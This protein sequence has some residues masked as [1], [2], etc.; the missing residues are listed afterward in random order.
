MS[1][2]N[3]E[4]RLPSH[5]T[6]L[7]VLAILYDEGSDRAI[8]RSWLERRTRKG[9]RTIENAITILKEFRAIDEKEKETPLDVHPRISIN[10]SAGSVGTVVTVQGIGWP[11]GQRVDIQMLPSTGSPG[12]DYV[13][14]AT[15]IV[16]SQGY[17]WAQFQVPARPDLLNQAFAWVVA[18]TG[19]GSFSAQAKFNMLPDSSQVPVGLSVAE[20]ESERHGGLIP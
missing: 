11:A 12:Q 5:R 10:P 2:N 18:T 13:P 3:S 19:G 14:L 9:K 7:E 1:V 4:K 6:A 17:F 16:D 8:S 15:S 20:M